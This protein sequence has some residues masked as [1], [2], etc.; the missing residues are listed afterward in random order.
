MTS[1]FVLYDNFRENI[2]KGIVDLA[3]DTIKLALVT[4][5]YSP[6]AAHSVLADVTASP[7][8]E[9]PE[10]GSPDSGYDTGGATLTGSTVAH[11]N[12][13]A[14]WDAD[15]VSWASLNATFRYGV[16]Y[17]E[18]T[19]GSIV[20]PLIGYILFDNTPGDIVKVGETMEVV[21]APTGILTFS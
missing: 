15:N 13:V 3:G 18:K 6:D 19:V 8:P 5:D 11:D 7:S 4:G 1:V 16:L 2:A 14:T 20:N 17:V 10:G 12:A 9:V 21:W